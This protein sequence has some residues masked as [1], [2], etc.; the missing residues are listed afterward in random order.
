MFV[1][2]QIV[3]GYLTYYLHLLLLEQF[4]VNIVK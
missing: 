4:I 1:I 2:V 3:S